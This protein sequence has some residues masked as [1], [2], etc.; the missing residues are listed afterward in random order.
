MKNNHKL[1]KTFILTSMSIVIILFSSKN[2]F[3]Q[4]I[5]FDLSYGLYNTKVKFH[6]SSDVDDKGTDIANGNSFSFGITS[7]IKNNL[8]LNTEIGLLSTKSFISIIYNYDEGFG[9][10]HSVLLSWIQNERVYFG[11]MPEY[12]KSI[13]HFDY[14]VKGGVL[15]A[16]DIKNYSSTLNDVF[17]I[18]TKPVL[19]LKLNTGLN[20]NI[21]I[22]ALKFD[23][24]F[25]T[26]TKSQLI[27]RYHP[28]ISY[29]N[30]GANIG[31]VYSLGK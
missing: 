1:L 17:P 13:K 18:K 27:N 8:F 23:L 19:G 20:W 10:K 7:K 14:Y 28:Y 30:F 5:K 24:G 31:V 29:T 15:L 9:E 21:G 25:M 3:A 2:I 26:F 22:I 11:I 6:H 4:K 12:R 16:N